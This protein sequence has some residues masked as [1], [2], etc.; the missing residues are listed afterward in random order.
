MIVL[1]R[2][3]T[4]THEHPEEIIH[5]AGSTGNVYVV[6]IGQIPTCNCPHAL[7]GNQ[8]KHIVYV[9]S[10][11]IQFST[12]LTTPQ[13]LTRTLKAPD[14]LRYQLAF[15]SC[16]LHTIF[17]GSP[18]L[19]CEVAKNESCDSGG[20]RKPIED[21]CPICC[22]AFD[23]HAA[24]EI[25]WCRAACGNN[26]HRTCFEQWATQKKSSGAGEVTCPFW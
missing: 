18:P 9:G 8:C 10:C 2:E 16:E 13:I 7:K 15:L 4:G 17:A 6:T 26:V 25:V 11:V 23:V 22:D 21:D 5:I 12:R 14:K 3:R 19:P 24:D 20:K 1:D